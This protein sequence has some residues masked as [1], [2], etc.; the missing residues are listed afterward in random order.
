MEDFADK[1]VDFQMKMNARLPS[2]KF[3]EFLMKHG[4]KLE[5]LANLSEKLNSFQ[6]DLSHTMKQ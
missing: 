1:L 6:E 5:A 2:D 3:M 4:D